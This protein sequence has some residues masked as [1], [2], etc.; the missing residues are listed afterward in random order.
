MIAQA[1]YESL[2]R[3]VFAT[4][5]RS[6]YAVLDGA[7]IDGLPARLQGMESACLFSGDLDPMLEAAAPHL[8]RIET[9]SPGCR[10]A[11]QEGWNRHWGIVLETAAD[12]DLAGM[13]NHLRRCL[14]VRGPDGDA[15]LFRFYDPRAFRTV[16]S[17]MKPGQ[18]EDFF[19][20]ILGCW[21]E[22]RTP[23]TAMYYSRDG[24]EPRAVPLAPA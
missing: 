9:D 3:A 23:D 11:L 16:V 7:Q 21:I 14:R 4:A 19:G 20:P 18:L 5:G 13:R 12:N 6:W 10:M 24:G 17:T 15:L 2:Q 22:G 8:L 1:Q